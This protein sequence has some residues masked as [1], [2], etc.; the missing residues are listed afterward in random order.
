MPRS[1]HNVWTY[2]AL[3][4]GWTYLLW[5]PA[6]LISRVS[7]DWWGIL[8]LHLLGGIGPLI[9]S[10]VI[11]TK[12]NNW[13]V[14]LRKLIKFN[15]FPPS[16]WILIISP[17]LIAG[18]G[19]LIF[20]RRFM[21]SQEFISA[22][23]FYGLLL[24]FFGPIPEEVGWRGVLFDEASKTS[25]LK[26]QIL[27]AAVWLI[28]H[29]PLFFITGSYQNSVGF[30]TPEFFIWCGELITQSIIMGYLYGLTRKSIASA[31]LFHYFV[32]LAGE[33]ITKNRGL[34]L[35]SLL[36]YGLLAVILTLVY[37]QA[38]KKGLQHLSSDHPK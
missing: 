1:K 16:L 2:I 14:Y 35:F 11:V 24:L 12:N 20:H 5:V 31:I 32:N 26:A 19:S 23:V 4:V 21:I 34:E 15:G 38:A 7:P 36:M 8:P 33:L 9:S 10:I 18:I 3:T 28:W 22:G 27:T 17:I 13:K 30:A 25:L 29:L 6:A 37:R